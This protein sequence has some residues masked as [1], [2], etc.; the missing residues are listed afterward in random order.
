ML[1]RLW[2]KFY[3]LNTMDKKTIFLIGCMGAGKTTLGR[4]LAR[5]MKQPFFDLDIVVEVETGRRIRD[6]FE[7]DGE[8]EFRRIERKSL[9]EL[10]QRLDGI[11]VVA[12]GGGTPCFGDNMALMKKMGRSMYI[13]VSANELAKRLIPEK[14]FRPIIKACPDADLPQFIRNLLAK[15]EA[16][17]LQADYV[18]QGDQLTVQHMIEMLT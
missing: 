8:D 13:Q 14:S 15:R 4:Q 18:L 2:T 5:K 3:R 1:H 16:W 7:E 17:Y 9:I 10:A 6:I 12:C 11:G